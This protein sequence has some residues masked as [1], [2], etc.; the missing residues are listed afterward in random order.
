MATSVN[1]RDEAE[2]PYNRSTQSVKLDGKGN[3]QSLR[4]NQRGRTKYSNTVSAAA[5]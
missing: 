4:I 3:Q 2:I 5:E 1:T